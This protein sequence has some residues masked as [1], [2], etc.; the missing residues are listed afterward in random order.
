[1]VSGYLKLAAAICTE[2]LAAGAGHLPRSVSVW[3]TCLTP[4]NE[5]M[6]D[7]RTHK[8]GLVGLVLDLL[9]DL[10]WA[11]TDTLDHQVQS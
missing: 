10:A 6:S 5:G 3:L 11:N 7:E 4:R 9:H 2:H 1:M 8:K